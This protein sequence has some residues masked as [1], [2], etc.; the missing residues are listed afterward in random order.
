MVP[1]EKVVEVRRGQQGRR[2]AQ[3]LSRLCAGED[4]PDRRGL[5]P[6]QE[7]AEGDRLPRRRQQADADLGRGSRAHPAARCRKASSGR[8]RRSPSRSASRCACRTGRSRR[9]TARS[10]R[11][12][13]SRSRLKVAV[14]IFGRATPVEL[15]F[16]Q[17]EKLVRSDV[18]PN[19]GYRVFGRDHAPLI[20]MR[21]TWEGGGRQPPR[22]A[23]RTLNR[24]SMANAA[25]VSMAKKITGYIKSA[26]AGGGGQSVAADRS[27]ARSA[28]PQHHGVLQGV[29]RADPEHGEGH[30]RFRSSSPSTRTAPSPSR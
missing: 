23:P 30:R 5:P 25:G 28:R 20:R 24:P 13:T 12:T 18:I 9:S 26:G 14:S 4:G 6:D 27:G 29:Q 19:S 8:S 3:V 10:R 1:T 21:G 11:S 15:E 16:G 2:R 17:V 7:H 22:S